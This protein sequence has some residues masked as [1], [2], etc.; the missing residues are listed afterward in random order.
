MT[1]INTITLNLHTSNSIRAVLSKEWIAELIEQAKIVPAPKGE[2]PN[3]GDVF[4]HTVYKQCHTLGHFSGAYDCDGAV[5]DV[6][7][8]ARTVFGNGIR[9]VM[10]NVLAQ[11]LATAGGVA[12][13]VSPAKLAFTEVPAAERAKLLRLETA[14]PAEL[15]PLL[16]QVTAQYTPKSFECDTEDARKLAEQ[17]FPKGTHEAV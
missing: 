3:G 13:T 16:P 14:K 11:F 9:K 7:L 2:E 5:L 1:D 10:G 6:E 15:Q 4:L 12:G 8:F 17:D